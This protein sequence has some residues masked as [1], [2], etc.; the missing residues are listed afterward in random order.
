M[1]VLNSYLQFS[2]NICAIKVNHLE[3]I[4]GKLLFMETISG[5][6]E[7]L[8][9]EEDSG[10]SRMSP[11]VSSV[12]AS[13]RVTNELCRYQRLRIVRFCWKLSLVLQL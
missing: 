1:F 10:K 6:P 7:T 11:S 12:D 2:G 9:V 3:N 13:L 5:R 8:N 4:A